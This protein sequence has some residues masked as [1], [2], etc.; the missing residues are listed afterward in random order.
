MA[1][2]VGFSGA[3]LLA[4]AVAQ[5]LTSLALGSRFQFALTSRTEVLHRR[6]NSK[7]RDRR[8]DK[9]IF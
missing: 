9:M 1:R 3:S 6:K 7:K 2:F 8:A 4:L 5:L